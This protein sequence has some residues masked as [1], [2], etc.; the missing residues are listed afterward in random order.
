MV[1]VEPAGHGVFRV[2]G[3]SVG[4][5]S[6]KEGVFKALLLFRVQ[7]TFPVQG[8]QGF[9]AGKFFRSGVYHAESA[10]SQFKGAGRGNLSEQAVNGAEVEAGE[11]LDEQPEHV[12]ETFLAKVFL[13]P[14]L[15]GLRPEPRFFRSALDDGPEAVPEAGGSCGVRGSGRQVR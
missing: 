3:F 9:P 4:V 2:R 15:R 11:L 6:G 5:R 8:E 10:D 12:P 14:G 1:G 7:G 13:L